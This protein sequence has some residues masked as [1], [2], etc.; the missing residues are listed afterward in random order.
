MERRSA[1]QQCASKEAFDGTLSSEVGLLCE[2]S[3][4]ELSARLSECKLREERVEKNKRHAILP[5]KQDKQAALLAKARNLSKI[6]AQR[7][8]ER[9]EPQSSA[10]APDRARAP[11]Q[12]RGHGA[13]HGARLA[14][15]AAGEARAAAAEQSG[16]QARAR[17]AKAADARSS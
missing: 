2:M 4:A 11:R 16:D 5:G 13:A 10:A 17:K 3:V 6:R 12:S 1:E 8:L 14:H 9:K 7:S 15:V